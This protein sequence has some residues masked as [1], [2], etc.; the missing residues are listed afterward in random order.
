MSDHNCLPPNVGAI[1][2]AG[3]PDPDT[4]AQKV[5]QSMAYYCPHIKSITCKDGCLIAVDS[6]GNIHTCPLAEDTVLTPEQVCAIVAEFCPPPTIKGECVKF[7]PVANCYTVDVPFVAGDCVTF[8]NGTKTYNVEVPTVD[9]PCVTFNAATKSYEVASPAIL[10]D[11]VSYDEDAKAYTI[12]P[13]KLD[14]CVEY[15]D[16]TKTYTISKLSGPEVCGLICEY[17]PHIKDIEILNGK[18]IASDSC[19]D[20]VVEFPFPTSTVVGNGDGT[21]TI[22]QTDGTVKDDVICGVQ[23]TITDNGATATIVQND[24]S[25]KQVLCAGNDSIVD[26]GDGTSTITLPSGDVKDDAVCGVQSTVTDNGVVA[27]FLQNDGTTK[28]VL[29]AGNDSIVDNGDGTSTITL[30]SGDVK[31]DAVCGIQS[32]VEDNGDGTA[33]ATFNDGSFKD[34]VVCGAQSTVVDNGDGTG[35]VTQND[36]TV[37]TFLKE[38]EIPADVF[39]ADIQITESADGSEHFVQ[40]VLNNGVV[41]NGGPVIDQWSTVTDNGDGTGDV[42]DPN[43]NTCTFVKAGLDSIV[44]NGDGTSTITL[45]GGDVKDDAV[46]GAQSSI[47]DNGDNTATIVQNDGSTKDV[48]CA[49][50]DS[51]VDNGDG[52][53]TITLAG[54]DSKADAVCGV[55]SSVV[56]DG[57]VATITQNDGST[58]DVLCAGNDSIVDNG[59]GTSTITL[60]SGDVKADAVCGAQSTVVDNGDGTA[61]VTQNDGTTKDVLCAGNDSIVDNGDGTSTI[62]LPSGDVKADAVCGAQSTIV[63]NGDGTAT[64]TQN[65]GSTKVVLCEVVIPPIEDSIVDNGDGTATITL[66]GGDVKADAVCGVQSTVLDNADG[67]VTLTQND[68]ST[69]DVNAQKLIKKDGTGYVKGDVIKPLDI[70]ALVSFPEEQAPAKVY[71]EDAAGVCGKFNPCLCPCVALLKNALSSYESVGDIVTYEYTI[72]NCG[73]VDLV[74]FPSL[75]DSVF[76]TVP[77]DTATIPLAPAA[78][79]VVSYDYTVTQEDVDAGEIYNTAVILAEDVAGNT[80]SAIADETIIAEEPCTGTTSACGQLPRTGRIAMDAVIDSPTQ[81]TWTDPVTGATTVMTLSGLPSAGVGIRDVSGGTA[82]RLENTSDTEAGT[83]DISFTHTPATKTTANGWEFITDWRMLIGDYD[84]VTVNGLADQSCV[85]GFAPAV[86]TG[87]APWTETP[88][89]SGV[90]CITPGTGDGSNGQV[91]F[92]D[93]DTQ[94]PV[95]WGYTVD[96]HAP[97]DLVAILSYIR[98]I[99]PV[100]VEIDC[101]GNI[102]SAVDCN[103]DPVADL[104]TITLIPA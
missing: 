7:D 64:V 11:C 87:S 72:H 15:N 50:T 97:L 89:G 46:C 45:S 92:D 51:I 59:D 74:S 58:K 70:D 32:F 96:V 44:D 1:G 81:A 33:T 48:L 68:G 60:P 83:Y 39:V 82:I 61:T 100:D 14:G 43:G 31:D 29:C 10:G 4:F 17:C 23:S 49:V 57:T 91:L 9:G 56:D 28:D 84:E 69:C 86:L 85:S 75:T 30:P 103:G 66:A 34:D 55:Q 2:G 19:G 54:G 78:S 24:G 102:D 18:L 37:C 71:G 8:D 21:A 76:G 3:C 52:T 99:E 80:V 35:T 101:D 79:T 42:T 65:D 38:V 13:I 16:L 63:D 93:V 22:T 94:A 95:T 98:Y 36:G 53:A 6:C 47:V 104:S 41:L 77:T 12:T 88:A 67:T 40:L 90:F 5:C 25:T 27:S 20:I 62:T 26:N 73:P